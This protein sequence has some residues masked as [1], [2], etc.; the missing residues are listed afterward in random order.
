MDPS[1][2]KKVGIP[3]SILLPIGLVHARSVGLRGLKSPS[4]NKG[5]YY[6]EERRLLYLARA[7]WQK[8]F[9]VPASESQ[10]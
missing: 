10:S 8:F 5:R 4:Q 9:F 6:W 3:A 7:L 1:T 2:I